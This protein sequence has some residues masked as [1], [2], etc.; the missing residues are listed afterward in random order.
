MH[1]KD[2]RIINV[3]HAHQNFEWANEPKFLKLFEDGDH[4]DIQY[5][6]QTEY[7]KTIKEFMDRC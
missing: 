5:S 1:T 7:F 2:D 4:S 3:H 6:N